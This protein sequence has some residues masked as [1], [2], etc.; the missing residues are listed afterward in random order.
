MFLRQTHPTPAQPRRRPAAQPR[1][2]HHR[3][4]PRT[5]RPHYQG[6]PRPQGGRGQDEEGRAALAQALPRPPLPPVAVRAG[7]RPAG[8]RARCERA[9]APGSRGRAAR[10]PAAPFA[11]TTDRPEHQGTRAVPDGLHQLE[12]RPRSLSA[13]LRRAAIHGCPFTVDVAQPKSRRSRWI[14]SPPLPATRSQPLCGP[15]QTDRDRQHPRIAANPRPQTSPTVPQPP[16]Q[17]ANSD[18]PLT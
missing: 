3:G 15:R 14:Q 11:A 6:V 5:A 4:H 8:L 7:R 13:A 9:P 1:A 17:T 16:P 10:D 12:P 2:A 18:Q